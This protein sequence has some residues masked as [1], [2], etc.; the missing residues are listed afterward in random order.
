MFWV[1]VLALGCAHTSMVPEP[2]TAGPSNG[3]SVIAAPARATT[4]ADWWS[5]PVPE[6]VA[7]AP[8]DISSPPTEPDEPPSAAPPPPT[9]PAAQSA[10]T[11]ELRI[12]ADEIPGGTE[13]R[14]ELDRLDMRY[15]TFNEQSSLVALRSD[16]IGAVRFR[17]LDN[18]PLVA[19]CRLILAFH[20]VASALERAGVSEVRYSGAYS[21]RMSRTGRLSLHA[22]GLAIDVHALVVDGKVLEV[23]R[24]FRQGLAA[25]PCAGQP[26]LN[27]VACQ[28]RSVHLFRELLTPDYDADHKNHFHLGLAPSKTDKPTAM[29]TRAKAAQT[30]PSSAGRSVPLATDPHPPTGQSHTQHAAWS[31][32]DGGWFD[33]PPTT[34]ARAKAEQTHAR[35]DHRTT[36]DKLRQPKVKAPH[37]PPAGNRKSPAG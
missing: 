21:Y 19:D 28:L 16:S 20:R 36:R 7:D 25:C 31:S 8:A 14:A 1:P 34:H 2:S 13:C 18:A 37:P 33:E 12:A 22:Y 26:P 3:G 6:L 23:E 32:D 24:D 27:R 5:A 30:V 35:A 15:G 9:C 11:A 29:A 4:P 17:G 10:L